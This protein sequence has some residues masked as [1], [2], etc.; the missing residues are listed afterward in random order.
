MQDRRR[1]RHKSF[2]FHEILMFNVSFFPLNIYLRPIQAYI[3]E[4]LI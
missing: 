4:Y 2:I 3:I 1:F